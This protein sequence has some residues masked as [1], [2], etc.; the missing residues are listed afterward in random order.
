M[1]LDVIKTDIQTSLK[2]GDKIRV[3]TLRF[4][5]AGIRNVAI[6]KYASRGESA[7]TDADVLDVIKK[8][9]KT[10]RESIEA[11]T[12]AKRDDL[13][14]KEQAELIILNSFLPEEISDEDLKKLLLPI[15]SSGEKN[16]GLL[17]KQAMTV[18]KGA[19]DGGRVANMLKELLPH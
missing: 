11:Y 6:A 10:H 3:G 17:M 14:N 15:A 5:L 8:Q 4:L 9:V 1:L 7:M 2:K 16:L 12:K 19:A 13:I 18:V